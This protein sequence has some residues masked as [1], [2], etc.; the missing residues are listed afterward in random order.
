MK[1]SKVDHTRT[2]VGVFPG[3]G[4]EGLLYEDPS[5][6]ENSILNVQKRINKRTYETKRLYSVFGPAKDFWGDERRNQVADAFNNSVK[7]LIKN[8]AVMNSD[9][10]LTKFRELYDSNIKQVTEY[11]VEEAVYALLKR[12]LR[13][14]EIQDALL[15]FFKRGVDGGEFSPE[16]KHIIDDVLIKAIKEDYSKETLA[17]RTE[18]AI[19]NQN[20]VIQP[21]NTGDKTVMNLSTGAKGSRKK[22]EK[23]AFSALLSE[24]AV[25]DQNKRNDVLMKIRRLVDL[26]F[27]G[28][29]SVIA[30]EFDV[31]EDHNEKKNITDCFINFDTSKSDGIKKSDKKTQ[32]KIENLIRKKNIEDYTRSI[33]V[34]DNDESGLYF[35]DK[36][37][38]RMMI[39]H[40]ENEVERIFANGRM[41]EH[42]LNIGYVSEK[43][44][45]G[46]IN[47]FSIKYIAIGKAVYNYAMN[48]LTKKDG[49]IELGNIDK[50]FIDGISSFEY[51]KIKAE[52]TLQREM[53]VYVSFAAN[54][55]SRAVLKDGETDD[56]MSINKDELENKMVSE[57]L[58][59]DRILQYFG[60]NSSWKEFN[61]DEHYKEGYSNRKFADDI[62]E[63]IYSM[64]N[65][66][67]HF[68]TE[69]NNMEV[70][71]PGLFAAM[72][73]FDCKRA[74]VADKNKFY[75]NNLHLF[76]SDGSLRKVLD[77]LYGKYS[78]R[79]SQVPSFERVLKR[80]DFRSLL[81]QWG[82][83]PALSEDDRLKFENG[84]YYL[85]KQIYYN[86]FLQSDESKKIFVDNVANIDIRT[87]QTPK[88]PRTVKDD[89]GKENFK[90]RVIEIK[91]R[92]LS[93]ICQVIMT[94][95]NM[96]NNQVRKKTQKKD[97]EVFLYYKLCLYQYLMEAFKLYIEK[98]D[99][100]FGFI[101]KP[102]DPTD[103]ADKKIEDF[104]PDYKSKQYE[105]LCKLVDDSIEL[106]KWYVMSRF[107]NTKQVNHLV[108]ALREYVHYADD[109]KRRAKETGNKIVTSEKNRPFD[110]IIRVVDM[111]TR[112]N[113]S[114]SNELT[115]YFT[116]KN[117]YASYLE[118]YLD[119]EAGDGGID[120][121]DALLEAFCRS[122][123]CGRR[124]GLY[125]DEANPILN[126]NI[127]ISK[128]YGATGV[129]SS[130]IPSI[131]RGD[132]KKY[133]ESEDDIKEYKKTGKITDAEEQLKVKR[134][135]EF[136]NR[137]ELRD[138]VEY[139]EIINELQGQLINWAYLR[140]R[141]LMYFQLGFHYM[142]L[143][144]DSSK[145]EGYKIIQI[146]D[147]RSI[148]G[149]I[150]YQIAAMYTAGV[151]LYY[152]SS[153]GKWKGGGRQISV[154]LNSFKRYSGFILS[155]NE[156]PSESSE[157]LYTAGLELFEVIDEHSNIINLRN[158]IDH[159]HYYS[160][161]NDPEKSR[162]MLSYYSEIF[163]RFFTY[164]MK[165]QKNVLNM[166]YN[167]LADHHLLAYFKMSSGQKKVGEVNKKCAKIE[168]KNKDGLKPDEF[169]FKL[170]D[171]KG[172]RFKG[173][174]K[175]KDFVE[176][177][178]K[179]L[180][181]PEKP[182]V[183]ITDSPYKY[184]DVVWAKK[185]NSNNSNQNNSGKNKLN[186]YRK[187]GNWKNK[188]KKEESSSGPG[189]FELADH[190]NRNRESNR[191][192][193]GRKR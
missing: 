14:E 190:Y 133:F 131:N 59:R 53:A 67:F 132:I 20:L 23:D 6:K 56:V 83:K 122:E 50:R 114:T 155:E 162:G 147:S 112:I 118:K 186:N 77:E 68:K 4:T 111:C 180:Y 182:Q 135:Q 177:V 187:Q 176:S 48:D 80:G 16:E 170:D 178:I 120:N 73:R 141:D 93:E 166:L 58:L 153:K 15:K 165:Y 44:W 161:I 145:P 113:G 87:E 40:I 8:A 123:V 21:K 54:H 154:K 22:R 143:N 75:S 192:N 109:V 140:E 31:W 96:Q 97:Q 191:N 150:L 181:Y 127:V 55:F 164:D 117:D 86:S 100:L 45:K 78:D 36:E 173:P 28:E 13:R 94:E 18:K 151:E 136:K 188:D 189:L 119:F 65:E 46:I 126:R 121:K 11:D 41:A 104:L 102:L 69:K 171:E 89:K 101:K 57:G 72:F 169:T 2:A 79:K 5:K 157:K 9:A 184:G 82:I 70:V 144:N 27:Y 42:K 74:V 90:A 99:D 7:I 98:H 84:V 88:G 1:I 39:H 137:I 106:K 125:Y 51:E 193:K 26:Y 34:I 60:G 32:R 128:L 17:K 43:V 160:D 146:N 107:L 30:E 49:N 24:Y 3:R 47:H 185:K 61:F 91:N 62:K 175:G 149:A 81:T 167:I 172:S 168:L 158:A 142:C 38:S 64:R 105:D 85:F 152:R 183:E 116:D 10:L 95:Y 19:K 108:G 179:I 156:D 29:D 110:D 52:E 71:D 163:D 92:S 76:Y 35:A 138:I 63:M 174:S 66:S 159:F 129:I 148:K 130:A 134:Y 124:I 37:I 33:G 115:D 25:L 103:R 139:S 12:S